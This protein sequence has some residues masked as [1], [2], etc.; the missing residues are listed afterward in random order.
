MK[1][2]D[3][4][5]PQEPAVWPKSL[6]HIVAPTVSTAGPAL[7]VRAHGDGKGDA[8][9]DRTALDFSNEEPITRQEF[10]DEADLNILLDRFGVNSQ[11]EPTYGATVDDSL[12]LQQALSA[13][14]QARRIDALVPPELRTQFP[15][16]KAVLNG[17][18]TGE[19]QKAL[20]DLTNRQNAEKE[21]KEV[22]KMQAEAL[23]RAK[24][25]DWATKAAATVIPEPPKE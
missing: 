21:Q 10:R 15:D 25:K 18:E 13:I 6:W 1:H 2:A 17:T 12:D 20:E 24:L 5:L 11:R 22:A 3:L 14:Q 4:E 19:Y 23:R 7:I 8:E 9:S 16:W